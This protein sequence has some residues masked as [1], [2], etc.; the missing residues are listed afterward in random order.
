M[1]VGTKI[2]WNDAEAP[3]PLATVT[4]DATSLI[5]CPASAAEWTTTLAV[6]GI[7]TGNPSSLWLCQEPS[8]S[9]ADAIGANPLTPAG[10]PTYQNANAGWTRKSV[11][12][13]ATTVQA[14]T[15]GAGVYDPSAT[16]VAWFWD[17]CTTGTPG[18]QRNVLSLS[19]NVVNSRVDHTA[20]NK[21]QV[22]NGVNTANTAG[23]YTSSAIA[24]FGIVH[25]LTAT[26]CTLYTLSEALTVAFLVVVDGTKG[27]GAVQGSGDSSARYSYSHVFVGAAAEGMTTAN[28]RTMWQTRGWSPTF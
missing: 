21:Y 7:A 28:V 6:A 17:G 3:D 8:G 23:S 5:Y 25:N 14:F 20:T 16:S 4:R 1:R 11:N 24:P 15:L 27:F 13:T 18:G 22:V 2:G 9:L 26:T 10:A 12:I 19:N